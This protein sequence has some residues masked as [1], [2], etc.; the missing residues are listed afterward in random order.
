MSFITLCVE[1]LLA[2]A[3][4]VGLTVSATQA[5]DE[6][7]AGAAAQRAEDLSRE[8]VRIEKASKADAAL[9]PAKLPDPFDRDSS[10]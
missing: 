9:G 1:L 6:R 7:A 2:L 4:A 3:K 5:I 10:N 8:D